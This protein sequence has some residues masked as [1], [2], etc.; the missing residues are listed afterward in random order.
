MSTRRDQSAKLIFELTNVCNFGCPYCIRGEDGDPH[1][2]SIGLLTR[3]LQQAKVY[4][5]IDYVA[6]T[7]GEPT[8]HPHFDVAM[9]RTVQ[10]G[11][12]FGFVTNAWQFTKKTAFQVAPFKDSLDAVTFSIDGA[13]AKTHDKLRQRDGSFARLMEAAIYCQSNGW[14]FH[15]NFVVTKANMTQIADMALLAARLRCEGLFFGHCQ[16]TPDAIAANL[17]LSA[18]ERRDVEAEVSRLQSEFRMQILFSGDHFT[19]SPFHRC[20]QLR[21]REF[22]VDF[23][24]YLTACCML[25]NFRGG[26]ED[27]DVIADL[28]VESFFEGHKKLLGKTTELLTAKIDNVC[29]GSSSVTDRFM[30]SQCLAHFGKVA[31]LN[32]ILEARQVTATD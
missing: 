15:V 20:D 26:Q 3:V 4:G 8:L 12:R 21:M 10:H 14:P 31:D 5:N 17:I 25:S 32:I 9:E 11:F 13:D 2:L 28:N 1:F 19:E 24:G 6:F 23:R 27:A 18:E 29:K 22:N 7:G 30:C 16:P